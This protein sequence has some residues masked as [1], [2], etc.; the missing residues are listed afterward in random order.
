MIVPDIGYFVFN[1]QMVFRINGSVKLTG[2]DLPKQIKRSYPHQISF[3]AA[4]VTVQPCH[5]AKRS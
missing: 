2:V 4:A 1:D 5:V 3:S